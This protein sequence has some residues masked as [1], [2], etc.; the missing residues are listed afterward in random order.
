ML[1]NRAVSSEDFQN[2]AF[3]S[4][5]RNVVDKDV[6][7]VLLLHNLTDLGQV[8][9]ILANKRILLSTYMLVHDDTLAAW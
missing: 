3:S 1:S 4:A 8:F 9:V 5:E 7:I 2:L 6:R